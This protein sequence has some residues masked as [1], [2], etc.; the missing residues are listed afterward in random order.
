LDVEINCLLQAPEIYRGTHRHGP[1]ADY[2]AAG[3]CLHEFATG[4]RPFDASRLQ[5]FRD[6]NIED[7]LI[8]ELLG[9][10][11]ANHLSFD[12]KELI[13]TLLAPKVDI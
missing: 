6:P 11:T 10:A 3:I 13:R 1:S 5:A 8:P 7:E 9:A 4:R 2:F 12:F